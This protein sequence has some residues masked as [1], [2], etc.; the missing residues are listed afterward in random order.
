M[1]IEEVTGT[2]QGLRW[3]Q[4]ALAGRSGAL[5]RAAWQPRPPDGQ[6]VLRRMPARQRWRRRRQ[7][8]CLRREAPEGGSLRTYATEGVSSTSLHLPTIV[9]RLL[10]LC[11]AG[12]AGGYQRGW[13]RVAGDRVSGARVAHSP[14]A[15]ESQPPPSALSARPHKPDTAQRALL[16]PSSTLSARAATESDDGRIPRQVAQ[17]C[18]A[19]TY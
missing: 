15:A 18:V 7:H 14:A 16:S 2:L 10:H 12:G 11:S 6:L 13:R 9:A 8:S 17:A 4:L 1:S 5:A 19:V 3:R